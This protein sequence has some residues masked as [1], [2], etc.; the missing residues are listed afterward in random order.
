MSSI[1]GYI[2]TCVI[3]NSKLSRHLELDNEMKHEDCS[4]WVMNE[5]WQEYKID[6]LSKPFL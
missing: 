2:D 4:K 5:I 3:F 1:N 6:E